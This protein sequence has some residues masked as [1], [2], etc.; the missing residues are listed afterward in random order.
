M[1]YSWS[2]EVR[3][4]SEKPAVIVDREGHVVIVT[5]NRPEARNALDIEALARLADAWDLIDGDD[6]V[7]VAILTGAGGHFSAGAD[8]KKMHNPADD[9]WK[10]RFTADP[11]LQWKSFLRDYQLKKPLIAAVEGT[12][13]AGGSEMLQATDIR[14][15]GESA[16]FGISEARWGLYPMAGSCVRLPRQIPYTIAMEM[17]LTGRH[18]TAAEALHFGL[19]GR[20]VPDGEA[21]ATAK[22]LAGKIAE[23]GPFAVQMIK[24]AVQATE[25]LTEKEALKIDL[26]YGWKVFK[27][28]DAKEGPKAFAEK[29]PANFKGR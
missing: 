7:R 1:F 28:E 21:L 20:V 12:C 29:R 8:L 18:V 24:S 22:Q 19:I 5:I 17:L 13:I 15:A 26:E 9:E 4:V 11:T 2:T 23:N 6:S 14:V 3:I 25:G 16:K 27:S 10:A